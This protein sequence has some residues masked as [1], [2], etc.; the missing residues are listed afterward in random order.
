MANCLYPRLPWLWRRHP[1]FRR[2][3]LPD[4]LSG[5]STAMLN[6]TLAL[7]PNR[8][9]SANALNFGANGVPSTIGV[10]SHLLLSNPPSCIARPWR[11]PHAY[12][13]RGI[14][15]AYPFR[16]AGITLKHAGDPTPYGPARVFRRSGA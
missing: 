7:Q 14:T 4:I 16:G 1:P 3:L 9:I 15:G 6:V 8:H 11:V 13:Y 2:W 10:G 12:F 5:T